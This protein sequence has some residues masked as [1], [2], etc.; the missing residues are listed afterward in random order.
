[1]GLGRTNTMAVRRNG[2]Q[3]ADRAAGRPRETAVPSRSGSAR[4]TRPSSAPVGLTRLQTRVAREIVAL[5]R[6]SDPPLQYASLGM[7]SVSHLAGELFD[8]EA[9]V[10]L[11]H[12][13]YNGSAPVYRALAGGQIQLAFVTLE[14]ALP[15]LRAQRLKV[16]GV[17]NAR[18]VARH[19]QIPAIAETLPGFELVGFFGFVAPARAPAAFIERLSAEIIR[20][21]QAPAMRNQLADDGVIVDV[22]PPAAFAAFLR[23]QV[24]KY[25]A[26]SR[27]TGIKLD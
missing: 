6:R 17:T 14:S 9:G 23:Q 25:A 22:A 26:L 19:P 12:V 18:R 3:K 10:R 21:L 13:P 11:Q 8:I 15:Q 1:M 2:Q 20:T 5:A 27:R 7:G 4:Q 24:D 16:L